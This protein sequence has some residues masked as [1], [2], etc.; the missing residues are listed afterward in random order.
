MKAYF[1]Y[2]HI[3]DENLFPRSL[4]FFVETKAFEDN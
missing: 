4:K 1:A 3:E 2:A